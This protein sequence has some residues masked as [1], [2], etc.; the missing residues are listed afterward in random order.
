MT[1]IQGPTSL[2]RQRQLNVDV[3]FKPR[4]R[5]HVVRVASATL[6]QVLQSTHSAYQFQLM[7]PGMGT[8]QAVFHHEFSSTTQ[9]L[10]RR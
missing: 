1:K 10:N 5:Q 6:E 2:P 3:A 4:Q 8:Y 7:L 9:R